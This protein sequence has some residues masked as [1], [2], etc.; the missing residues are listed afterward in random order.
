MRYSSTYSMDSVGSSDLK[1]NPE[2]D[3]EPRSVTGAGQHVAPI[4]KSIASTMED[5]TDAWPMVTAAYDEPGTNAQVDG[6]MRTLEPAA[7]SMKTALSAA[8]AAMAHFAN[9]AKGLKTR[10]EKLEASRAQV[11]L[12]INEARQNL[13]DAQDADDGPESR[14]EQLALAFN[15]K[16]DALQTEW[17]TLCSAAAASIDKASSQLELDSLPT[18]DSRSYDTTYPQRSWPEFAGGL[19]ERLD[20][21]PTANQIARSIAGLNDEDLR[22]W[23]RANPEG[24]VILGSQDGSGSQFAPGSPEQRMRDLASAGSKANNYNVDQ[25]G[26][27]WKGL[28]AENQTFLLAAFPLVFGN[29]NGIPFKDRVRANRIS[30]EAEKKRINDALAERKRTG[31]KPSPWGG[32]GSSRRDSNND[33]LREAHWDALTDDMER[34]LIGLNHASDSGYKLL[35]VSGEGDGRFAVITGDITSSTTKVATSVPG[36]T[37]DGKSLETSVNRIKDMISGTGAVG[38]Y[39]QNTDLPD[40]GEN[41][42]N[43]GESDIGKRLSNGVATAQTGQSNLTDK[44]NEAGAPKLAAFDAALDREL[45]GRENQ[46]SGTTGEVR[47]TYI[48]HSAGASLQGTAEAYGLDS[49]AELYVAPA[50]SGTPDLVKTAGGRGNIHATRYQLQNPQDEI[51]FAQVDL[52]GN[53]DGVHFHGGNPLEDEFMEVVEI[54]AGYIE[55]TKGGPLVVEHDGYFM[56]TSTAMRNIRGVIEGTQILPR[57]APGPGDRVKKLISTPR[58]GDM[59]VDAPEEP[60]TLRPQEYKDK[61]RKHW[62][63]ISDLEK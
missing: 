45:G 2:F 44:Y 40:G 21:D 61:E 15:Q 23:A 1:D 36:T 56:E 39:W 53:L 62:K 22:D 48:A 37:T 58:G 28:S 32:L 7:D 49:T 46:G 19:N 51:K 35:A 42:P 59:W 52:P 55:H 20:R 9:E 60:L 25:V 11:Q 14:P 4:G 47:T 5:I 30:V 50:G 33:A 12:D 63:N 8:E 18:A 54:E 24:T 13:S 6:A 10:Q 38:I 16:V 29:M 34:A 31:F 43:F 3:V 26:D 41:P 17:A 27:I 57:Q